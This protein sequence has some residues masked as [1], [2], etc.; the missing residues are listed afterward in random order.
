VVVAA[1]DKQAAAAGGNSR[2]E[3]EKSRRTGWPS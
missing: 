3:A 1:A 2:A